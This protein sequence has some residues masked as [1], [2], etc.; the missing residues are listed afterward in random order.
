MA[1]NGARRSQVAQNALLEKFLRLLNP[2][3]KKFQ[4][5]SIIYDIQSIFFKKFETLTRLKTSI[6]DAPKRL[7][8]RWIFDKLATLSNESQN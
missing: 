2:S 4:T 8:E 5:T 1:E 3:K 7:T 6:N